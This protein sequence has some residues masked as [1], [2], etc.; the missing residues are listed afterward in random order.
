MVQKYYMSEDVEFVR[1]VQH[2]GAA[3]FTVQDMATG[4]GVS[5]AT[6][7]RGIRDGTYPVNEV[8]EARAQELGKGPNA[9]ARSVRVDL[10]DGTLMSPLEISVTYGIPLSTV[11]W[12]LRKDNGLARISMMR[13]ESYVRNMLHAGARASIWKYRSPGV[14]ETVSLQAIESYVSRDHTPVLDMISDDYY[15]N[16]RHINNMKKL[17]YFYKALHA[18][19]NSYAGQHMVMRQVRLFFA[20]IGAG[21]YRANNQVQL[22]YRPVQDTVQ[23]I[24]LSRWRTLRCVDVR[25]GGVVAFIEYEEFVRRILAMTAST[26]EG[27]FG[28]DPEA[29]LGDGGGTPIMLNYALNPGYFTV[30]VEHSQLGRANIATLQK[31]LSAVQ[32]KHP[33][34][35][36]FDAPASRQYH[37]NSCFFDALRMSMAARGLLETDVLRAH[38]KK[39]PNGVDEARHI[40]QICLELGVPVKLYRDFEGLEPPTAPSVYGPRDDDAFG[41]P[42]SLYFTVYPEAHY[43]ALM[44]VRE[45]LYPCVQCRKYCNTATDLARHGCSTKGGATLKKKQQQPSNNNKGENTTTVQLYFDLETVNNPDTLDVE[46]YSVVWKWSDRPEFHASTN[47]PLRTSC[48]DAFLEDLNRRLCTERCH[49]RLV[50]Y[51]GSSFDVWAILKRLAVFI[52]FYSTVFRSNKFY[53]LDG[54]HATHRESAVSVWDPY[55]YLGTS[56]D[57]AAKSFGLDVSKETFDHVDMQRRYLA[58]GKSFNFIDEEM[59]VKIESYNKRDVEI[60]ERLCTLLAETAPGC[61][62]RCTV[63]SYAFN[64]LKKVS[65]HSRN[66]MFS[67]SSASGTATAAAAAAADDY[68]F[69]R[70]AVTGGRVEACARYKKFTFAPDDSLSLI[71]VVSLYPYVMHEKPVPVGE[72]HHTPVYIEDCLG[73]YECDI[74]YQRLPVVIPRKEPNRPLDWTYIGP[75]NGVVMTSVEIECMRR[76]FG[77]GCVVPKAGVFWEKSATDVFRA[78]IDRW[79]AVKGAEDAKKKSGAPFNGCLRELAKKMLNT[80]YG[81]TVQRAVETGFVISTSANKTALAIKK[82]KRDDYE[83]CYVGEGLEVIEGRYAEMDYSRAKPVHIGV[84]ILAHSRVKMYDEIFSRVSQVYYSDTDSAL[85]KTA[86]MQR[87]VDEGVIQVGGGELGQYDVEMTD[88]TEFWCIEPKCYALR[89]SSGATKMRIKGVSQKSG[90]S[91]NGGGGGSCITLETFDALVRDPKSVRFYCTHFHHRKGDFALEFKESVKT[92]GHHHH[93]PP[94]E[95][96]SSSSS[97]EGCARKRATRSDPDDHDSSTVQ[98]PK[99]PR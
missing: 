90:W 30:I 34:Y 23:D 24:A 42:L 14:P 79:M 54:K 60:L 9:T 66:L 62:S 56:L 69:I 35:V 7:R 12:L 85:I 10:G 96:S 21:D 11:R 37:K 72:F 6:V 76:H 84:F 46:V 53:I 26:E 45:K 81:K 3:V 59:R 1:R 64:E 61:M 83:Y 2:N 29:A 44:G 41:E 17:E 20:P 43:S 49:V 86:D 73:V 15:N 48:V 82:F 70:R 65:P 67:T 92:M 40:E 78:H 31:N 97:A 68:K 91:S 18:Q 32:R 52:D 99:R 36:L 93:P 19:F 77:E 87:L 16:E 47:T 74:R 22:H 98:T 94:S 58:A 71:D 63:S 55:L 89:N 57:N 5:E 95:P 27:V 75:Q 25:E 28:S 51:N 50:A 13:A 33:Y 88:I 38:A 80:P 39:Y 4:M 8:S